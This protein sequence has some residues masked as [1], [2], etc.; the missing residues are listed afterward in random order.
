MAKEVGKMN[1]F[2]ARDSDGKAYTVRYDAANAMEL[3]SF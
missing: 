2:A 3:M 1:P